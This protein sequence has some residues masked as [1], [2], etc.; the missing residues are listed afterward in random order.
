MHPVGCRVKWSLQSLTAPRLRWSKRECLQHRATRRKLTTVLG[1]RSPIGQSL[2]HNPILPTQ[3]KLRICDGNKA[4]E[5]R[6]SLS[7]S[8]ETLKKLAR[9]DTPTICNAVELFDV[10]PRDQGY[11]NAAIA[12]RFPE[13]PPMVGFAATAAFRASGM[14]ASGEVYG[15]VPDQIK[16]F[17]SL[18]GPAVV[19]FQDLDQPCVGATFGE[20][21]CRSYQSFG[22]VGLITSGA[23]RDLDQVQPLRFPVFTN[24]VICSHGFC[25]LMNIGTPVHVGGLYIRHGDLIHGDRNGITTIPLEIAAEVGDAAADVTAAERLLIEFTERKDDKRVEDLV[26]VTKEVESKF[27]E[28]RARVSRKR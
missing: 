6:N 11:M 15:R 3:R 9:F 7:I 16:Q 28:I 2:S 22:A 14:P 24:S 25:H 26:A 17:E 12:C 5:R 23:G 1:G 10:R 20:M 8:R 4:I 19:V 18:P 27:A 13:L 21:M